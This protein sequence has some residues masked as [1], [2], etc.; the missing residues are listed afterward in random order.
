ME[1]LVTVSNV[2]LETGT[3]GECYPFSFEIAYNNNE[4]RQQLIDIPVKTSRGNLLVAVCALT[5]SVSTKN[6]VEK[7]IDP[8]YLPAS[9]ID[10]RY[11]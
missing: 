8:T 4:F 1:L 11:F 9:V 6:G 3:S 5:Y 2:A 10:A 7:L